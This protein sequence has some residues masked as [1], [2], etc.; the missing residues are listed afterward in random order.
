MRGGKRAGSGR[1]PGAK[2]KRTEV[3]EQAMQE[4]AEQIA[5]VLGPMAFDGDA[6]ALLISLYKD[7]AQPLLIR[8]DAAKAAISYEKP[9]LSSVD[10]N[11]DGALG[12][13]EAQPVPIEE[14]HPLESSTGPAAHS[15]PAS[16]N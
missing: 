6:H 9:R 14:R 10:A 3:R 1:P 8:L 2:N 5:A 11:I 15:D 4:A 12:T 13:Y 16:R 7:T